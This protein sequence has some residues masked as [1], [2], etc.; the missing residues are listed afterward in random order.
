MTDE[1]YHKLHATAIHNRA[2]IYA[3][4]AILMMTIDGDDILTK[5]LLIGFVFNAICSMVEGWA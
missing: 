4:G 1:Q 2:L 5:L 3:M